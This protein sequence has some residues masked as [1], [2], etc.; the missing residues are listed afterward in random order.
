MILNILWGIALKIKKKKVK[1]IMFSLHK[2]SSRKKA[3]KVLSILTINVLASDYL[4]SLNIKWL[5]TSSFCS[6][7]PA[8]GF[9]VSK[10]KVA[11]PILL[12][13]H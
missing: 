1:I 4:F 6:V 11:P 10:N 8:R 5:L 3:S 12:D 2:V 13:C 9:L 7:Y